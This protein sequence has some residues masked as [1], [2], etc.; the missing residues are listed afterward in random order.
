[1]SSPGG[2]NSQVNVKNPEA[3]VWR[4]SSKKCFWKLCKIHREAP[5]LESFHIRVRG[6]RYFHLN[7]A[8]FLIT[9]ILYNKIFIWVQ[10][11]NF[12]NSNLMTSVIL[13]HRIGN[14]YAVKILNVI[15]SSRPEVLRLA[16]LFKKRLRHRCF[17]VNFA[18]FLKTL[19]FTEHLRWLLL[20][21]GDRVLCF[22]SG[23]FP[24]F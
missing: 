14:V 5:A 3:V 24:V 4:C 21:C 7:S 19:S 23:G 12:P 10:F 20:L 16:P 17:P 22:L 9:P 6:H 2:K 1:M 18:K 13:P 8:K 15:R 11:N